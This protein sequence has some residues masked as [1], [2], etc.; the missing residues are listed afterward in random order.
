MRPGGY[1]AKHDPLLR[2]EQ[3]N[4]EHTVAPERVRYFPGDHLRF[5]KLGW[6]HD[7]RLP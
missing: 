5:R 7:M 6:A 2:Q 3:F 4:A 1:L